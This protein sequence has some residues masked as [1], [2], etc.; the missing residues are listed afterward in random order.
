MKPESICRWDIAIVNIH[1]EGSELQS[2][3]TNNAN[4]IRNA[5]EMLVMSRRILHFMNEWM[6]NRSVCVAQVISILNQFA[7]RAIST[8]CFDL[9]INKIS[10]FLYIT[11][12]E[13]HYSDSLAYTFFSNFFFLNLFSS[14]VSL[15]CVALRLSN[16]EFCFILLKSFY[17]KCAKLFLFALQRRFF[18]L[19]LANAIAL[20]KQL[21]ES[22]DLIPILLP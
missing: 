13:A 1:S 14:T 18:Y 5:I 15:R 6:T 11:P 20:N 7:P 10:A 12:S 19:N 16:G 21:N 3:E 8:P 9:Q 4:R 22:V 2:F 17:S